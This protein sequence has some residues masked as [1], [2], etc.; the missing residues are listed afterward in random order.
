MNKWL[1]R[2]SILAVPNIFPTCRHPEEA[3]EVKR[4]DL[5]KIL[6]HDIIMHYQKEREK[7]YSPRIYHHLTYVKGLD[8]PLTVE[9][10]DARRFARDFLRL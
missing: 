6:T 9:E 2:I 4:K 10:A 8:T 3:I 7:N 1:K 5:T